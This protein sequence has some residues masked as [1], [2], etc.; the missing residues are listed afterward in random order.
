VAEVDVISALHYLDSSLAFWLLEQSP[1]YYL[2]IRNPTGASQTVLSRMSNRETG[3]PV[4]WMPVFHSTPEKI[5]KCSAVESLGPNVVLIAAPTAQDEIDILTATAETY[6]TSGLGSDEIK[7]VI[8]PSML[9]TELVPYISVT[10]HLD[11]L[12]RIVRAERAE[13][14]RPTKGGAPRLYDL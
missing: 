11:T 2:A 14:N 12:R 10:A 7:L 8:N 3:E 6:K 4:T 5:L 1:K 13:A 9:K